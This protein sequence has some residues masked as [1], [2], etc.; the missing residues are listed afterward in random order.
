MATRR[1][2]ARDERLDGS[3][4]ADS[5]LGMAG[6]D[7]L[8]GLAGNDFLDGGRGADLMA[9]G[10]GDDTY[11]V[12]NVGDRVIEKRGEG[13][14]TVR[15]PASATRSPPTSK[16]CACSA[17]RRCPAAAMPAPINCSATARVMS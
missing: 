7:R 5:L 3:A 11:V 4:V 14:D 10:R 17:A 15:A 16:T 13:V 6:N 9:G 8:F 1:G 12:D 2:S